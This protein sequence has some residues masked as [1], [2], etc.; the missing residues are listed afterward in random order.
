MVEGEEMV[1]PIECFVCW[2]LLG[3][4]TGYCARITGFFMIYAVSLR[5]MLSVIFAKTSVD[6]VKL[7]IPSDC[8]WL[9][10]FPS[11]SLKSGGWYIICP[12]HCKWKEF[13]LGLMFLFLLDS[14]P[15]SYQSELVEKFKLIRRS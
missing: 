12:Y 3:Q 6:L 13:C 8:H 2:F 14:I 1:V 5:S 11:H 10:L 7:T 4:W 15:K 9:E